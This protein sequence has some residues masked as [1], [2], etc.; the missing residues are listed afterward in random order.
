M[1]EKYTR[2]NGTIGIR[3]I[4]NEPDLAQ[5]QYAKQC[6]VNEIMRKYE[7]DGTI[8][9]IAKNP[10]RYQ[11]LGE[12]T[13]LLDAQMRVIRAEEAFMSLPASLRAKCDHQPAN[14]LRMLEDGSNDEEL[15]K[16]GIKNPKVVVDE[17]PKEKASV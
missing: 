10:G 2:P 7:K 9:H 5:Q 11:Q 4:N 16:L 13:D 12:P 17:K 3:T 6:D 1:Q 15:I 14:F 8:T